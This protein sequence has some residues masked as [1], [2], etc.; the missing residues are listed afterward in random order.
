M[1]KK[2]YLLNLLKHSLCLSGTEISSVLQGVWTMDCFVKA[3]K[4]AS[5][6]LA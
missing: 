2:Y 4:Q 6:S 5:A 1:K 3:Y